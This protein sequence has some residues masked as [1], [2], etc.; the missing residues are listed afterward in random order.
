MDVQLSGVYER[1]I[2]LYAVCLIHPWLVSF[3][4]WREKLM[5]M[6]IQMSSFAITV[7][8]RTCYEAFDDEVHFLLQHMGESIGANV[9][10]VIIDDEDWSETGVEFTIHIA[11]LGI[12][13]LKEYG[14]L[15]YDD[16]TFTNNWRVMTENLNGSVHYVSPAEMMIL[17]EKLDSLPGGAITGRFGYDYH[18]ENVD[19]VKADYERWRFLEAVMFGLCY[20]KLLLE[21]DKVGDEN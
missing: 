17:K 10:N 2:S 16:G 15:S 1:A 19:H 3:S 11:R 4:L 7:R 5:S 8:Y 14:E 21:V 6:K 9:D 18:F 13:G 12:D 20:S